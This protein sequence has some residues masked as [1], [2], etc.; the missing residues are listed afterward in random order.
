MIPR[1]PSICCPLW[2]INSAS[3]SKHYLI[4]EPP[5]ADMRIPT[6]PAHTTPVRLTAFRVVVL[7]F[8]EAKAVADYR[9]VFSS[10]LVVAVNDDWLAGWNR[11][12]NRLRPAQ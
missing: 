2:W 9:W 5:Y 11:A 10:C 6:L 12:R 7:C 4:A 1:S 8:Q 3:T